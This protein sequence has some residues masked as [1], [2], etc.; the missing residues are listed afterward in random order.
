MKFMQLVDKEKQITPDC[1]AAYCSHRLYSVLLFSFQ[2]SIDLE[3]I[4]CYAG[5]IV[6]NFVFNEMFTFSI[7]AALCR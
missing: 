3:H 2:I 6:D 7:A 1:T 5:F 4:S